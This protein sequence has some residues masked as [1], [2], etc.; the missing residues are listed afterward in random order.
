MEELIKTLFRIDKKGMKSMNTKVNF[1]GIEMKNPVTVA[2]GTFGYGREYADFFDLGKLGA[3][4]T[5]GTSLRP[6]SGNKPSRVCETPS[7]MLNSIGL[8]NPGVEYFANNDLPYLRKFDTKIIVNACGSSIDEYVELC[9]I[10]NDLD[11]D[12]VELNLSCPNVKEGCMAFGNTYEGVKK[13]TSEVRKVLDKPLI[14]KL[15]SNVTDIAGIAKGVEDGGADAV[16]LINT[17]LAMKIDIYKR[18]PVL[19]NNTGGLSGPAIRPVA[20]RMVYQVAQA[21]N[22]PI[23]GLGGIVSG[24]DAIEFMLAGA[25]TVSIG[26]GNFIDPYTSVKTVEG[27]EEYMRKCNIEDI[28][29][30]IGKVE[31]N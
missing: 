31:M 22:I 12:G 21:V 15:T 8:Q 30:I 10:L 17:L 9:K 18:K 2:S 29:D 6:K 28:N 1:A 24:E 20:V 3:I 5:K 4:I 19:A 11:I 16:S 27:I 23:M 26:A 13:V 7:G 14:V 25:T